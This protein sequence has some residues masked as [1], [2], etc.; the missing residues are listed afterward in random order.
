MGINLLVWGLTSKL[1]ND[2]FESSATTELFPHL[3]KQAELDSQSLPDVL[4]LVSS[5]LWPVDMGRV[6]VP[7][8]ATPSPPSIFCLL[9]EKQGT[10]FELGPQYL[11]LH[12][13]TL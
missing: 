12:P 11:S 1:T 2:G 10:K 6:P 13:A 4:E 9:P 5:A 7:S 8:T 3:Y